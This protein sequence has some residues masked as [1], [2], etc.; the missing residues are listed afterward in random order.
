M[1][2]YSSTRWHSHE[3]R[4]TVTEAFALDARMLA[5]EGMFPDD[6]GRHTFQVTIQ[7]GPQVHH[8]SITIEA[9][10]QPFGGARW[11]C[12]C[13]GCDRRCR[14]LYSMRGEK[15]IRCRSCF[16]LAYESQR[17]GKLDRLTHR[18]VKLSR[19]LGAPDPS[20]VLATAM[21]PVR[22]KGMHERTYSRRAKRLLHA[23]EGA[24]T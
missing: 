14:A 23:L 8:T 11:W 7:L 19:R 16:G 22:P 12:R 3:S 17:L 9:V 10:A 15:E 6:V 21:P 5:R 1:G 20:L 18:V 4:R 24:P 2:S 13:G